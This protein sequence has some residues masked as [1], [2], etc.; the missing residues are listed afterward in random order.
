MNYKSL[1]SYLLS[2]VLLAGKHNDRELVGDLLALKNRLLLE[3]RTICLSN[4]INIVTRIDKIWKQFVNIAS[5]GECEISEIML[6]LQLIVANKNRH[7]HK[8]I[9]KLALEIAKEHRFSKDEAIKNSKVL[10]HKFLH[11][12]D[13]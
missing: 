5:D 13:K 11:G 6:A 8:A 7:K 4:K 1:D 3:M 12:E 10:V 2:V 9:T